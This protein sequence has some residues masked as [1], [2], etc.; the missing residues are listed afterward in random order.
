MRPRTAST[1]SDGLAGCAPSRDRTSG[2][3]PL[4]AASTASGRSTTYAQAGR[5]STSR[6]L[7][8]RAAAPSAS[9]TRPHSSSSAN[10]AP[11][12]V[13]RGQPPQLGDDAVSGD[14]AEV[15]RA[16]EPEGVGL[17]LEAETGRVAGAAQGPGGIVDERAVV[18]DPQP[19]GPQVVEAS[20]RV[21][22]LAGLGERHR[23]RVDGEVAP[24]QVLGEGRR[25]HLGQ[26]P[27]VRVGLRAGAGDVDRAGRQ[28]D[29]RGLEAVVDAG[30]R[31]ERLDQ[32]RGVGVDDQV[33]VAHGPP[34]QGVADGAADQVGVRPGALGSGADRG[35]SGQ[36]RDPLAEAL[37]VYLALARHDQSSGRPR[38]A[39]LP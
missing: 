34:Q 31:P 2:P 33:E 28:V 37:N 1:A 5:S 17:D 6:T 18:Q 16:Q 15:G 21:D 8:I 29:R 20:M 9:A 30:R 22:D 35:E 23:E 25:A 19:A 10:P 14:G 3:G 39:S 32:P 24:A 36:R 7:P 12:V 4:A 38:M 11:R 26:R 27:R 13:L